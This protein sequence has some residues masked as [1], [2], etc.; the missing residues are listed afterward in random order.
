V[1]LARIVKKVFETKPE[2]QYIFAM[3]NTRNPS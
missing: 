1:D 3:D 2:K